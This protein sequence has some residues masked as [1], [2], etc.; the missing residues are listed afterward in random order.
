[1]TFI[2][3]IFNI[4]FYCTQLWQ[5]A[6]GIHKP[7]RKIL[8][9]GVKCTGQLLPQVII[10]SLSTILLVMKL[11]IMAYYEKWWATTLNTF[12]SWKCV[13]VMML[14]MQCYEL[15]LE[16]RS[17]KRR[18]GIWF[19]YVRTWRKLWRFHTSHWMGL[20]KQYFRKVDV[21][22]KWQ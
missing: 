21:T 12:V 7:M 9:N 11:G 19:D 13:A 5:N 6:F 17:I 4:I 18:W 2:A 20:Y 14:L 3:W 15:D 8:W 1:M 16:E 10:L 22:S